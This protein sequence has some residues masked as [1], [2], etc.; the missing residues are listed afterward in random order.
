FLSKSLF[1]SYPFQN[2]LDRCASIVYSKNFLMFLI[3]L[4]WMYKILSNLFILQQLSRQEASSV[5][6][7]PAIVI[8]AAYTALFLDAY[9]LLLPFLVAAIYEV[10]VSSVKMAMV[11]VYAYSPSKSFDPATASVS[12]LQSVFKGYAAQMRKDSIGVFAREALVVFISF[13]M[14]LTT[15]FRIS[16][17]SRKERERLHAQYEELV[18]QHHRVL[19]NFPDEDE[20]SSGV[21]AVSPPTYSMAIR[22]EGVRRFAP[23]LCITEDTAPPSYSALDRDRTPPRASLARTP[24]DGPLLPPL[25]TPHS[26]GMAAPPSYNTPSIARMEPPPPPLSECRT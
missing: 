2:I 19:I 25:S 26:A 10:I 23:E 16:E 22:N 6:T 7:V 1:H 9:V 4:Y 14:V 12:L 8:V 11:I 20:D 18:N 3:L 24:S 13:V 21:I 5:I 17:I 15:V